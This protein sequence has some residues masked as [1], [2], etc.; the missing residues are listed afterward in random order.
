MSD[1][2]VLVS[3]EEAV[4]FLLMCQN[5]ARTPEAMK[6]TREHIYYLAKTG[7]LT[8]HGAAKRGQALWDLKELVKP[9]GRNT[10]LLLP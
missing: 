9:Y 1:R 4:I 6:A 2:P 10:T 3:T 5:K 7:T 8:R